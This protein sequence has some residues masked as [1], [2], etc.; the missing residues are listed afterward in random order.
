MSPSEPISPALAKRCSDSCSSADGGAAEEQPRARVAAARAVQARRARSVAGQG[1]AAPPLGPRAGRRRAQGS[2]QRRQPLPPL[3]GVGRLDLRLA[4]RRA[5]LRICIFEAANA[6]AERRRASYPT[7]T[8]S[9]MHHA[10]TSPP[11]F[12]HS[13]AAA[14]VPREST[15]ASVALHEH[16]KALRPKLGKD[17]GSRC[18]LALGR[19]ISRT[20]GIQQ[21]VQSLTYVLCIRLCAVRPDLG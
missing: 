7:Q 9:P 13:V 1:A 3:R 12:S 16:C 11:R 2:H 10:A 4:A 14:H 5:V 18:A 19:I 15:E 17:Q 21:P 8:G 6:V 20:P